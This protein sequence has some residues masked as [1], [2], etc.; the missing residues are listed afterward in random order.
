MK[1]FISSLAV[2]ALLLPSTVL[3]MYIPPVQAI[4]NPTAV[5]VPVSDIELPVMEIAQYSCSFSSEVILIPENST[6][7]VKFYVTV[8]SATDVE[9]VPMM[10]HP[11]LGGTGDVFG[12]SR[13]RTIDV[14]SGTHTYYLGH[15]LV[16]DTYSNIV[17]TGNVDGYD[18]GSVTAV[19]VENEDEEYSA[20]IDAI[21]GGSA[22][23]LTPVTPEIPD[24]VGTEVPDLSIPE[25]GAGE[26]DDPIGEGIIPADEDAGP[27]APVLEA[28]DDMPVVEGAEGEAGVPAAPVM[29]G[30]DIPE[31]AEGMVDDGEPA[32]GGSG[33]SAGDVAE[34][35]DIELTPELVEEILASPEAEGVDLTDRA[36]VE[37]L[38]E[39]YIEKL[40][41]ER[42]VARAAA[43][44]EA[45]AAATAADTDEEKNTPVWVYV[46]Y[47]VLPVLL[48]V[49]AVV[50]IMKK[51]AMPVAPQEKTDEPKV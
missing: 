35:D 25:E 11:K 2:V 9:D 32:A 26:D 49:L 29:E 43:E 34:E 1:E 21:M 51:P 20:L 17:V 39:S 19:I 50:I 23:S 4:P 36:E 37:S 8:T 3:G 14:M 33:S 46:L 12:G 6:N 7:D 38:V 15:L 45:A 10:W 5:T 44:E 18:C 22:D 27:A 24:W 31:D 30:D 16:V 40:K 13:D 28:E 42:A 41:E 48:I 47:G